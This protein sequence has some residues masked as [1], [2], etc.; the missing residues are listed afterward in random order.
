MAQDVV[1]GWSMAERSERR[2]ARRCRVEQARHGGQLWKYG[3]ARLIPGSTRPSPIYPTLPEPTRTSFYP[4]PVPTMPG[5]A[6]AETPALEGGR[7]QEECEMQ[8]PRPAAVQLPFPIHQGELKLRRQG[9]RGLWSVAC[10]ARRAGVQ[11]PPPPSVDL[12][13]CP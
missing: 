5:P 8:G 9:H 1:A 7:Q 3:A 4:H 11:A 13:P 12:R 10:G 6:H 2:G